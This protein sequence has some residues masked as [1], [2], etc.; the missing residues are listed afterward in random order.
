M[1]Y[2]LQ[3]KV[4]KLHL[5][6]ATQLLH[7][8]IIRA[9]HI[10]Y[11]V[12]YLWKLWKLFYITHAHTCDTCQ[13]FWGPFSTSEMAFVCKKKKKNHFSLKIVPNVTEITFFLIYMKIIW[14]FFYLIVVNKVLGWRDRAV[15]NSTFPSFSVF[16]LFSHFCSCLSM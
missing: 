10:Y 8:Y 7:I 5:K 9:A 13:S 3:I 15:I 4:I 12:L 2:S 1:P 14:R 6:P 11:N 16:F